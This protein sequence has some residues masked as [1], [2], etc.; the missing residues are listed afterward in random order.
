MLNEHDKSLKVDFDKG[1]KQLRLVVQ[2]YAENHPA[3]D[4]S[5]V[6]EGLSSASANFSTHLSNPE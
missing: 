5:N 3:S 2:R 4:L 6:Y 1:I